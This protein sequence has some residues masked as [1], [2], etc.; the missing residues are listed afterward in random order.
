MSGCPEKL[1]KMFQQI[2]EASERRARELEEQEHITA[3]CDPASRSITPASLR[4]R[5][6]RKR[7]SISISRFG[8]LSDTQSGPNSP[9]FTPI[10]AKSPFYQ[11]QAAAMS[12]ASFAS[13]ASDLYDEGAYTED[14]TQVTQIQQ[15]AGKPGLTK[16][17]TKI[18]PRRL[19][20]T[21]SA[22]FLTP[23]AEANLVI[24]VSVQ[25]STLTETIPT[26]DAVRLGTTVTVSAPGSKL[27]NKASRRTLSTD[28]TGIKWLARARSFTQNINSKLKPK[29]PSLPRNVRS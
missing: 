19:S 28:G 23:V 12:N 8:Q 18:L 14:H 27:H 22:S 17:V 3:L 24:G 10:A 5:R 16:A 29:H 15:I 11:A 4:T 20:R 13:G 25:E 9:G 26:V 6:D 21:K 2:E 7:G 1:E